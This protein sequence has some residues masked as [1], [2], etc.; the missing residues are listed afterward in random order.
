MA[1]MERDRE[2]ENAARTMR[3]APVAAGVAPDEPISELEPPSAFP[4]ATKELIELNAEL[5]KLPKG[6]TLAAKVAERG[7]LDVAVVGATGAVG[8]QMIDCLA[9]RNFPL[10]RLRV[11]GSARTAGQS[12]PWPG[13]ASLAAGD[14]TLAEGTAEA[15]EGVDLILG[16]AANDIAMELYP[17]AVREGAIVVDNSSAFR[18]VP[19][20]PLVVPEINAADVAE[21]HGIIA[22]PNCATIICLVAVWPLVQKAGL[23]SMVVSTY[24]AASGAGRR[25][26]EELV[27]QEAAL[28]LGEPVPAPSAFA[29]QLAL[30]LIPQIGGFDGRGYTS[31][32]MKLQNEGRKIMHLPKLR[33]GCTC[34]RVPVMRSHA[35]SVTLRL[36]RP[37]TPSEARELLRD[38]PGVRLVDEPAAEPPARRYP[39]PLDT[40]DQ[41]LVYVGR[42]REDLAAEDPS[43]GLELWCC[44]DQIR[45]GAASNTVQIAELLLR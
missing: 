9:E 32:E 26:M 29:Y 15:L 33:V 28:A 36:E 16:A 25:G 12:L 18:L 13:N 11:L 41:D 30:N 5:A 21:S 10:T 27:A 40:S 23:R 20:V 24:Q 17:R 37:L 3:T 42:I 31:E 34:V 38:A 7:G 45:K 14:L 2:L 8:R 43:R 44:G 19:E 39:M 1:E 35:E 6:G 4:G 22:N